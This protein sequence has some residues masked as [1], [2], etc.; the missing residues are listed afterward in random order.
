MRKGAEDDEVLR[1]FAPLADVPILEF[2]DLTGRLQL[3]REPGDYLTDTWS[4]ASQTASTDALSQKID[5]AVRYRSEILTHVEQQ[6]RSASPFDCLCLQHD[7]IDLKH[8]LSAIIDHFSAHV[9]RSTTVFVAGYRMDLVGIDRF[10]AVWDSVY[11][12]ALFDW[13]GSGLQGRQF[14][15]VINRLICRQAERVH[16]WVSR[17]V[18]SRECW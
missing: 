17:V 12:L 2:G 8:N 18:D 1:W 16:S 4:V 10:H 3:A 5:R 14:S 9:G 13:N 6:V 7:G 15:S 11:A